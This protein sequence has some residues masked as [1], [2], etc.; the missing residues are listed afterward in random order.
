MLHEFDC[1]NIFYNIVYN[2][3][4]VFARTIASDWEDF[5]CFRKWLKYYDIPTMGLENIDEQTYGL[6]RGKTTMDAL[7]KL[8]RMDLTGEFQAVRDAY[9][10]KTHVMFLNGINQAPWN[11][12]ELVDKDIMFW[13][14]HYVM[15][16]DYLSLSDVFPAFMEALLHCDEWP[17]VLIFTQDKQCF[18]KLNTP[19][20]IPKL[21]EFLKR[22]DKYDLC[23]D[24]YAY[25]FHISDVH[26]G[27]PRR[28]EPLN[29]LYESLNNV[30]PMTKTT[31][32]TKFLV[33]GDLMDSPS[34]R[35]M[36]EAKDFLSVLRK[37]FDADVAFVLGNHDVII[38]GLNLTNMQ[39][40]KVIAYLLGDKLQV[41][42]EDK[43]I[44]IKI[45]SNFTGRL[46][47]GEVGQRQ[48][49]EIDYALSGVRHLE[50]YTLVAMLHHHVYPV[51]KADFLKI[52]FKEKYLLGKILDK[53]KQLRDAKEVQA[54][55]K[56][57]GVRYVVHGHKHVPFFMEKD[58]MYIISAGSGTGGLQ[59]EKSKYI[60]YNILKYDTLDKRFTTC[61]IM[62]EDRKGPRRV[63]TETFFFDDK[64]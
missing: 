30:V 1:L 35:N 15:T 28:Y 13:Q 12:V 32:H 42:P 40:A 18:Y 11:P 14:F 55:L 63:R 36:Y 19:D 56:S 24:R 26:L 29:R 20:D 61:T 60:T 51:T 58:G 17:G 62:Y 2:A 64:E 23:T 53:S 48:M 22:D 45:D 44:I 39:K 7:S 27:P 47:R 37:R 54:W 25:Y 8:A 21:N 4:N 38:H 31:R 10:K 50:D 49:A 46:A 41:I 52:K 3:E 43:V 34:K 6:W 33:S 9:R 5:D 16:K 59:E 57:I